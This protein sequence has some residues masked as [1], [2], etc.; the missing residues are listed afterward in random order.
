MRFDSKDFAFSSSARRDTLR[1]R[2]PRL[3]KYVSIRMPD[4]GPF[5][6]T[7]FEASARAISGALFVKSPFA[8]CVESEVTV[9][10]QRRLLPLAW[11]LAAVPERFFAALFFFAG[12][13][14]SAS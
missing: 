4:A 5:G 14:V 2:P 11:L 9:F 6:D 10:T 3:M 13:A 1:P 8:G 12:I 7:F